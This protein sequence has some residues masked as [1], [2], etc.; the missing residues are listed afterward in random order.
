[1]LYQHLLNRSGEGVPGS[2]PTL[3]VL[4]W[5]T[6]RG[7]LRRSRPEKSSMHSSELTFRF[8][9]ACGLASGRTAFASSR[10]EMSDRLPAQWMS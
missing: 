9:W 8:F 2:L 7:H 6:I 3:T 10:A 5:R 1:M 4:P